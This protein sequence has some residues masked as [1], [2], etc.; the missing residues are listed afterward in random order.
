MR[1]EMIHRNSHISISRQAELLGFSRGMLYDEAK[2]IS[3]S[4]LALMHVIDKLHMAHPD[5]VHTAGCQMRMDGHGA[6]RDHVMVER[7]CRSVK[8]EP[9]Y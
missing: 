5:T 4:D 8:Y 6:W 7:L 1:K 9:V 2:P 3:A